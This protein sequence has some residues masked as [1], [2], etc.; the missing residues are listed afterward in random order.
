MESSLSKLFFWPLTII[1]SY[2]FWELN[3]LF[4]VKGAGKVRDWL[5][6]R[7]FSME[8]KLKLENKFKIW[9]FEFKNL[10]AYFIQNLFCFFS[11]CSHF[12]F[13]TYQNLL[14]ILFFELNLNLR[15]NQKG[16]VYFLYDLISKEIWGEIPFTFRIMS[17]GFSA[18]FIC[19]ENS[20]K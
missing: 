6:K 16:P 12:L 11:V 3:E 8:R 15:I 20:I 18:F 5:W 7:I 2:M 19:L 10:F 4:E 9:F 17:N 1:K 13:E 14:F